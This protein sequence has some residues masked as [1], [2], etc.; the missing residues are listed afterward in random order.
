MCVVCLLQYDG[1]SADKILG[2][3]GISSDYVHD[4]KDPK[5]LNFHDWYTPPPLPLT[6]LGGVAGPAR[7]F[8]ACV[9]RR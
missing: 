6:T 8:Y 9:M 4:A 3:Y 2:V 5:G 7:A 1:Q